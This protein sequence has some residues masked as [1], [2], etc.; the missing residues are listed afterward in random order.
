M[1]MTNEPCN[2]IR[3]EA[4]LATPNLKYKPVTKII[5]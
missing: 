4:Q 2:L 1:M 5:S 3:Q